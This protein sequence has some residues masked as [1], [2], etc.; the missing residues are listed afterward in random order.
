MEPSKPVQ[1]P[2][3]D[4][5][6]ENGPGEPGKTSATGGFSRKPIAQRFRRKTRTSIILA[7]CFLVA[8]AASPPVDR[9]LREYDRERPET[10]QSTDALAGWTGS[11]K[12]V[13]LPAP[14]FSLPDHRDG[15]PVR[16]ADFRGK[17][18]VVLMFGSFSCD[19][20]CN[21]LTRLEH[22]YEE[23]QDLA[24]FLFIHV[25]D[26]PHRIPELAEVFRDLEPTF[27]NRGE[28]ARRAMEHFDLH[29][30][31]LI[32]TADATVASAYR[33]WPRR[34][35]IVDKDGHIALDEG[36]GL[37]GAGWDLSAVEKWLKDHV[38]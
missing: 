16:L 11:K 1:C 28:R 35:L 30:P 34:L 22:L 19:L 2:A 25:K 9:L 12:Q 20:F 29:F 5:V 18:P 37:G 26:A 8:A 21:D 6:R 33:A 27:E 13:D 36:N 15:H 3:A 7:V 4:G 38:N 24:A 17:R 23:H 32:D 14:E 10:F 31:C